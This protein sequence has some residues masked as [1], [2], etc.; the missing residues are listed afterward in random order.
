MPFV[1]SHGAVYSDWECEV[2]FREVD[3]IYQMERDRQQYELEADL[4]HERNL[5]HDQEDGHEWP[6]YASPQ[7]EIQE[8]EIFEP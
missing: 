5:W 2:G 6:W 3:L 4:R 1:C 8:P 7:W